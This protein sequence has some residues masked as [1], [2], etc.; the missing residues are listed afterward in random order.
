MMPFSQRR[1]W[2]L[3]SYMPNAS[4][5]LVHSIARPLPFIG[6]NT[7]CRC[8]LLFVF[9]PHRS[10]QNGAMIARGSDTFGSA[11]LKPKSDVR[12]V[13][14]DGSRNSMPFAVTVTVVYCRL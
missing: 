14:D 10:S 5:Q 2:K 4:L 8:T 11:M 13:A 9:L 7:A 12:F 3:R 6:S 1:T